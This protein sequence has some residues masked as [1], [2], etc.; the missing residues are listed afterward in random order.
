[1][2]N[3]GEN[4]QQTFTFIHF[5]FAICC[6]LVNVIYVNSSRNIILFT[7][8]FELHIKTEYIQ[9]TASTNF[10][11]ANKYLYKYEY[12]IHKIVSTNTFSLNGCVLNVLH[13]EI[14]MCN[15]NNYLFFCILV[16]NTRKSRNK[17]CK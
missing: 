11:S 17:S 9:P 2:Y 10:I 8:P 12:Y 13:I 3:D 14:T 15:Q 5:I 1:M 7:S 4:T 6:V 16:Y